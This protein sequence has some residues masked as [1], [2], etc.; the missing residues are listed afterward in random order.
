MD[1]IIGS[2]VSKNSLNILLE[3]Y[4]W[5]K[6]V[7]ATG[8]AGAACRK[9][10]EER[11]RGKF[12]ERA[13]SESRSP[14]EDGRRQLSEPRCCGAGA[15][16]QR[17]YCKSRRPAF[18]GTAAGRRRAEERSD[19]AGGWTKGARLPSGEGRGRRTT[20]IERGAAESAPTYRRDG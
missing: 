19:E 12:P 2:I 17:G 6:I 16:H 4:F 11:E 14:S 3:K 13:E 15:R 9:R 10:K 5:K 7:M 8:W 1:N 20:V 18:G